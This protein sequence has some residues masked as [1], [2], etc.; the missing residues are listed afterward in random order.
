MGT[1]NLKVTTSNLVDKEWAFL[2]SDFMGWFC[3]RDALQVVQLFG[4]TATE[5]IWI[6]FISLHLQIPH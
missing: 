3:M 4:H 2:Q 5:Y 1:L 6:F